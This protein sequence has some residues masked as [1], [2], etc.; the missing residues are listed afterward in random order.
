MPDYKKK[1]VNRLKGA[2]KPKKAKHRAV[3]KDDEIE[4]TPLKRSAKRSED[5]KKTPQKELKVVKGKKLERKRKTRVFLSSVAAVLIV[6]G[7][8]HLIL[9]VGIAENIG[10]LTA[11]IG[12]G[13]YPIDLESSDTLNTV[14]RGMYYYV[15]TNA[16]INAYSGNGKQIYSYAHGYENPVLKTSKTRALIFDQGGNEAVIYNLRTKKKTV[17]T[18]YDIITAD[19]SDSGTYAIVTRS[20][21]YASVVSVYDKHNNRLYEWSSSSD[22]VN[23][24]AVSSGGKKIA[25]SLFNA[26][27]GKFNS[28]ISVLEYDSATPKYT[29]NIE[30][31]LVYALDSFH[32]S[33]FS[34]VTGKG[35]G[36]Y[37]WSDFKKTEYKSDYSP[38]FLRSGSGGTAIVFN[39]ESDRADNRIVLFS[40][41]GKLKYEFDYK[42]TISDIEVSGGHIYCISDTS[43]YLLSDDGKALSQADCG[44][45]V[46]HIAPIGTNMLAAVT[47]NGIQKI[48]LEGKEEK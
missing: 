1:K 12:G 17:K 25:V 23:N 5:I 43:A 7:V 48:K 9:P 31:T 19:I 36:F 14:S 8:L 28:K 26:S 13:S 20:D 33:G 47:D 29:E 24:V 45:G 35:F 44:F 11:L 3:P 22:T 30:E 18:D 40:P 39:R 4:M 10:N 27:S 16:Y 42:G 38:A 15:L 6:L 34:A 2:F 41:K 32:N 46:T 21:K 37:A